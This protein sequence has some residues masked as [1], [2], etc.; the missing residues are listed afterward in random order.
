MTTLAPS[1]VPSHRVHSIFD[2]FTAMRTGQGIVRGH[3]LFLFSS[4][5]PPTS[6]RAP[7]PPPAL[8]SAQSAQASSPIPEIRSSRKKV[9][10]ALPTIQ[11]EA[12][13]PTRPAKRPTLKRCTSTSPP[14]STT[15]LAAPPPPYSAADEAQNP[16]ANQRKHSIP[17]SAPVRNV[18]PPSYSYAASH[19]VARDI[20][21]KMAMEERERRHRAI[22]T[23][24]LS[25]T[26]RSTRP[27]RRRMAFGDIPPVP[28]TQAYRPSR[29]SSGF[30]SD[31]DDLL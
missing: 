19:E 17:Q 30:G 3:G 22:A 5:A 16:F 24:L 14:T 2:Q 7:P 26:V 28:K 9:N 13:T 27:T 15:P 29:L 23:V 31:D 1:A 18:S 21:R 20:V 11:L 8:H 10:N 25:R 4:S 12:P 6:S